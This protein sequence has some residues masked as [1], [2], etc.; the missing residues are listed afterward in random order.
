MAG[1]A[2]ER[3]Q[4]VLRAIVAD[5][6]AAQEPIGSK[7]LLERHK[8]SVSSATIRN[9]MAVLESEGYIVQPHTSSG[10]IPTEKGY[11]A[12]V[13][14][15]HE[16]KPLSEPERT[17]ILTFL[18]G[19]VDL[20]DVLRRSVQLLSQLTR[21][22]AVVAMPNLKVSR[23]KHCEVVLL[24]PV[25][26]L[27][28]LIT[29]SGR[30]E[31]RNVE[32]TELCEPEHVVLLRDILNRALEGK[33]LPDASVELAKLP[34]S[35]SVPSEV[36]GHLLRCSTVLLE[37]L[38]EQPNDRLILAG[39]ANL[40]R[41]ARD[42]PS[43]LHGVLEALEEQVVVLKLLANVADLGHVSVLIGEENQDDQL[44]N[45]SVV[46]AGYGS[47]GAT[48]GGLGVVGPTHM[49][50]SGTMSKVHAVARYVSRV[51]E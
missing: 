23:V 20:E 29:D 22:A 9:D 6:I 1:A 39:A 41:I 27:L 40:T 35:P 7:A 18:E 13:D 31:Q 21:Q 47:A 14:S 37:T 30:V 49:D 38:V 46:A 4:E 34:L 12:F 10:R 3:R 17:A 16:V 5:Y 26:L 15:L 50:Y 11:R 24:S 44:N 45:A 28:V 25:R 33:T 32:L 48:L 43:G 19:G 51:L 2:Q 8:L 42:F 36:Q